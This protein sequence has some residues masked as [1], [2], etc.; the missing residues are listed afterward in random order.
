MRV[1]RTARL[2]RA[3]AEA[4][5]AVRRAFDK[6]LRLLLDHGPRYPSLRA[7]PWPAHGPE[8]SARAIARFEPAPS[9]A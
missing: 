2:E 6:Q 1:H 3:Y 9:L 4:P 7:H 5:P 8:R